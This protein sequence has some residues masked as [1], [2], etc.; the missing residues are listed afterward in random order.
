MKEG[1][2][3]GGGG[4]LGGSSGM[5]SLASSTSSSSLTAAFP[6]FVLISFN[7][8]SEMPATGV[9]CCNDPLRDSALVGVVPP[10]PDM[11]RSESVRASVGTSRG[12]MRGRAGDDA[13]FVSDPDLTMGMR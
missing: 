2:G 9:T 1:G 10:S 8:C 5:G 7:I 3:G 6:C 13:M 4:I 11:E 12:E